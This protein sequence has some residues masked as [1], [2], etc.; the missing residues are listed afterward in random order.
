MARGLANARPPGSAKFA[1]APTPGLTRQANAPQ[2]SGGL[3]GWAQV[4]LTDAVQKRQMGSLFKLTIHEWNLD[5][6]GLTVILPSETYEL[7]SAI[8]AF[9]TLF[10][11]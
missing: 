9:T 7:F 1:N 6:P 5:L 10:S 8:F 3:G 11:S 4:E 2:L